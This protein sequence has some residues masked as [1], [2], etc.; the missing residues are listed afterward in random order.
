MLALGVLSAQL[1]HSR[2]QE[3]GHCQNELRRDLL[4][5]YIFKQFLGVFMPESVAIYANPV[6]YMNLDL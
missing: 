2:W 6:Q 3:S 5:V 4:C 1:K